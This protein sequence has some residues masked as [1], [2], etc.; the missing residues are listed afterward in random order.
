MAMMVATLLL[1]LSAAGTPAL[2]DLSWMAGAWGSEQEGVA[3][4]EHW[5]SPRGGLM[6][7]MHRDVLPSGKAFF[8]F[9]RI[10]ARPDG[11]VYVAMPRGQAPTDFPLKES[12]ARR[13]VFENLKH[14]FPQRILYWLDEAG[15]LNARVE[16]PSGG[17][18]RAEQWVWEPLPRR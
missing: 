5:T 16:G 6:V 4:E 11:I 8:E 12:T 7:G 17:R 3:M 2:E 9:L 14:D 15:R 13:V 18:E 1:V 10:E